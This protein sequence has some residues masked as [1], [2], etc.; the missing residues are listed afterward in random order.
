MIYT[1]PSTTALTPTLLSHILQLNFTNRNHIETLFNYYRGQMTIANKTYSDPSKPCSRIAYPIPQYITDVISGYFLGS[2]ITYTSNDETALDKLNLVLGSNDASTIDIELEKDLSICGRS[3]ELHYTDE[4]GNECF[5]KV[6]PLEVVLIY[7]DT[8]DQN[9]LYG[10]RIIPFYDLEANN[11]YYKVFVYDSEKVVEYKSDTLTSFS[12]V[13][14]TPH[15]YGEVPIIEYKNNEMCLGD[16]EE[17]IPLIDAY[18]E[19]NSAQIDDYQAFVDAFLVIS[20]MFVDSEDVNKMKKQ[21]VLNIDGEDADVKWLTKPDNGSTLEAIKDRLNKDIHKYSKVPDL[22]DS[23][24]ASNAS[25]VAIKYKLVGLEDI[26][27]VKER[28]FKKGLQKRIRL[29]FTI[30]GLKDEK[31]DP[32]A[33]TPIFTRSLPVNLDE[34]ADLVSKLSGIVSTQTLLG[35]VPFIEDVNLELEQIENELARKEDAN[36]FYDLDLGD[37][38]E[39]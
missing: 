1:L 16:F 23:S 19:L 17:V 3:Y 29:I 2:P 6:N 4:N 7:D 34:I 13:G 36:P 8:I 24:F 22:S 25:G 20:G 28:Y 11:N 38:D 37:D 10:I 15:F 9:I 18:N 31:F 21:R 32:N 39:R 12:F 27:S 30:L 33:I 5:T 14:E 35:Q 26:V